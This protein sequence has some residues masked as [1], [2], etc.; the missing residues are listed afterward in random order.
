[1]LRQSKSGRSR[2]VG[3]AL[4]AGAGIVALAGP[5]VVATAGVASASRSAEHFSLIDDST[6][7]SAVAYSVVAT[8]A[9]ADGGTATKTGNALT[10]QLSQGSITLQL[11]N[12]HKGKS[13]G[14]GCVQV[15]R[16]SGTYT[17]AGGTGTYAKL[18]GS[19]RS[20]GSA[21]F[22]ETSSGGSCGSGWVAAQAMIS[23]S[24]PVSLGS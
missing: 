6:S 14:P 4:V 9:F 13:E 5:G 19:G 21:T 22:V 10:M 16:M 12:A 24:G 2:H 8:G 3:T 20:S 23:G 15:Q 18:T 7:E 17:I 11:K 1:M